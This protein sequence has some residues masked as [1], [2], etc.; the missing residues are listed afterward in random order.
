[1]PCNRQRKVKRL[2]VTSF[3]ASEMKKV[4]CVLSC[5]LGLLLVTAGTSFAQGP[6]V[7]DPELMPAVETTEES[8]E[9]EE[10][11]EETQDDVEELER[12]V[13]LL[14][15]ELERLRS[16]E[17]ER[18]ITADDARAMGLAPGA[19]AVFRANR[20]LSIAGYGEFLYEN[21]A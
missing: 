17:G 9:I 18:E 12:R 2:G 14:A 4:Q 13:D 15:E 7:D 19:A 1:M 3:T 20:G 11:N 16:G 5:V 10:E 21:Y 6:S 8:P